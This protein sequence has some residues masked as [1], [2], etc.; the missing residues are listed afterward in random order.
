H[1][2]DKLRDSRAVPGA[3]AATYASVLRYPAVE[4][5]R[6]RWLKIRPPLERL[7]DFTM[8]LGLAGDGPAILK[9]PDEFGVDQARE[10]AA[11]LQTAYPKWKEWSPA[12]IAE[13]AVA[14][15]RPTL[16][17]VVDRIVSA[18]R[19]EIARRTQQEFPDRNMTPERWR[20]VVEEFAAAADLNS[21]RDLAVAATH[22]LDPSAGEPVAALVEF[23][24]RDRFD[25]ELR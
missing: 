14:I 20:K 23:V 3:R 16:Q 2:T 15:V 13:S 11:A 18:G 1:A 6:A 5:S 17:V 12:E 7:H 21:W 22:W 8:A 25:V 4:E 19:R 24:R 10:V 9:L